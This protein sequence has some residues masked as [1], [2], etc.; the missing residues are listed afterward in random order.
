[1]AKFESALCLVGKLFH[2]VARAVGSKSTAECIE[3][4]YVWKMG[5]HYPLWKASY[6]HTYGDGEEDD[7]SEDDERR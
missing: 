5:A 2:L 6:T 7:S 4:F 3:F 1:M